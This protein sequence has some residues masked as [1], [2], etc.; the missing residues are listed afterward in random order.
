MQPQ[1]TLELPGSLYDGRTS[2][3][4]R[5]GV[6]IVGANG[7]GKTRLGA[8]IEFRSTQAPTVHRISAQKSL[9]MP[10]MSTTSS[11]AAAEADLLYGY[12]EA[13]P[14]NGQAYKQGNRWGGKPE[15]I[16][17]NDYQK[18]MVYLFSEEFEK[19]TA[20]RQASKAG[21][22][23]AQPGETKLDRIKRIWQDVLPHRELLIRAGMVEARSR[24]GTTAAYNGAEMS[25]GE[26]VIFYAIGQ[27]LA[28]PHGGIIVIDEPEIHLHRAVQARLWDA[29][30]QERTDCLFVY[31]THDLDFA[32][33]RLEMPKVWV[34]SYNGGAWDWRL[35]PD[36]TGVPED[37]LLTVVGSRKPVLFCEG[38]RGSID[39]ALYSHTYDSWTVVPSGSCESVIHATRSFSA[40]HHLHNLRCQ[41]IVDRDQRSDEEVAHL[42][43]L[44]VH[45]IAFAEAESILASADVVRA[46]G[47]HLARADVEQVVARVDR[48]VLDSLAR[49]KERVAADLTRADI[50]SRVRRIDP[51]GATREA[52]VGSVGALATSLD[53]GALFDS[54]LIAVDE[55]LAAGDVSRAL[56]CY[57]HKG[58]V[59]QIGPVLGLK[60]VEYAALVRRL[61]AAGPR[62]ALCALVRAKLP[63]LVA[64]AQSS[65]VHLAAV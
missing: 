46:V 2:V 7:S 29:I 21:D 62:A 60:P 6:V 39:H 8:W 47:H 15:T 57:H 32:A 14:A 23:A 61:V 48:L 63:S 45:A 11:M 42:A 51:A 65:G 49:D 40:L 10:A 22:A 30:E 19:S 41:G 64:D 31:I 1:R 56:R 20:F 13:V 44:G 27:A 59:P 50:E 16:L 26:R 38:D 4:T 34:R 37:L 54:H 28:A 55:V 58:I 36:D 9:A 5:T 18:L 12:A 33:S 25:D 52:L 17:L 24:D 43:T 53:A 3:E 35:V